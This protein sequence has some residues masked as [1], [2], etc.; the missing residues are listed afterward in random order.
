MIHKYF[1]IIVLVLIAGFTMVGCGDD[2]PDLNADSDF[3]GTWWNDEW[4]KRIPEHPNF[5]PNRTD[6]TVTL[7]ADNFHL[8]SSGG[9]W[10]SIKI[11]EWKPALNPSENAERGKA[12]YPSGYLLE[13]K[14]TKSGFADNSKFAVYL[15][16]DGNSLVVNGYQH[17]NPADVWNRIFVKLP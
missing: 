2:T 1:G 13:G 9:S 8:E 17:G 6:F 14:I 7:T 3:F 5:D 11:N 16:N 10:I 15:H 12:N 4:E